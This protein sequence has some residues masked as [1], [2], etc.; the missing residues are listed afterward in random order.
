MM[1]S[2]CLCGLIPSYSAAGSCR[3]LPPC[4]HVPPM[5]ILA[6]DLDLTRVRIS[7]ISLSL[8]PRPHPQAWGWGLGTRLIKILRL[9]RLHSP[10]P[11]QKEG[12]RPP[13]DAEMHMDVAEQCI[14]KGQL[15]EFLIMR[16]H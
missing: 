1:A 9:V 10:T 6:P 13:H 3:S 12:Q 16:Y 8:V 15:Q 5:T 11:T 2:R 14:G 4:I 7:W